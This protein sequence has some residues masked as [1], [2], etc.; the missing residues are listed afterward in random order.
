MNCS[1]IVSSSL[2]IIVDAK[3]IHMMTDKIDAVTGWP[4]LTSVADVRSFLG[5]VGYYRKF[6][7]Y[8][9]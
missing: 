2:V 8:V 4:T 1:R 9:Q 5:T 7:R 3:G 6:V